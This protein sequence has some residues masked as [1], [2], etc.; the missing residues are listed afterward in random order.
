MLPSLALEEE[1]VETIFVAGFGA[2]GLDM[3]G[4]V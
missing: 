2:F 3:R 4:L 1:D